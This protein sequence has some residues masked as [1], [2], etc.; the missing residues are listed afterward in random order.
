[1]GTTEESFIRGLD[2]EDV[3]HT[4]NGILAIRKDKVLP[5]MTTWMDLESIVLSKVSQ[6]EKVKDHMISLV[7][8]I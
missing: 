1:M 4:Y 2:K 3:V 6:T 8:G 7:C 5:L